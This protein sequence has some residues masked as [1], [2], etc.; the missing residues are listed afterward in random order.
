M[1]I[2]IPAFAISNA[3]DEELY[4]LLIWMHMTPFFVFMDI[5]LL[6][7]SLVRKLIVLL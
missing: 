5:K 3:K 4:G 7:S 1:F 6:N 2:D